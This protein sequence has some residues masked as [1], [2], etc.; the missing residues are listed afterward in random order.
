VIDYIRSHQKQ[1]PL[2]D[3]YLVEEATDLLAQVVYSDEIACLSSQ[4]HLLKEDEQELIRLRYTAELP[5]AEIA[6]LLDSNENTV[7]KSLYRI[8]ARLQSQLEELHHG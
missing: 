8:M 7:K 6:V 2:Q 5:F 4:I 3:N 1:L